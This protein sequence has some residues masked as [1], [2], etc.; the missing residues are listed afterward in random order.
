MK[1]KYHTIDVTQ[2]VQGRVVM[3]NQYWLCKDGD[4]KQAI[5]FD[6]TAQCNGHELIVKRALEY[7]IK[8]SGWNVEVVF[9]EV[10]YRP[11]PKQYQY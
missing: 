4:P 5:F 7:T 10:A 8:K 3:T 1:T 6:E 2:P 11:Q 9:F